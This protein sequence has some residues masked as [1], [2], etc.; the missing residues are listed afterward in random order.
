MVP[1]NF[2]LKPGGK[3]PMVFT[4]GAFKGLLLWAD[5]SL[6]IAANDTTG[7]PAVPAGGP[8]KL[9]IAVLDAAGKVLETRH[10]VIGRKDNADTTPAWA[11]LDIQFK[12]AAKTAS[13]GITREDAG[14]E[15]IGFCLY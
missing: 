6:A 9:R 10:V 5:T 4:T 8:Q 12:D 2:N 15:T 11:R 13:I 3:H 14:T 1:G 7:A